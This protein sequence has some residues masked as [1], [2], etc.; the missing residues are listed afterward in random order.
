MY[1]PHTRRWTEGTNVYVSGLALALRSAE[2]V[3]YNEREGDWSSALCSIEVR[4]TPGLALSTN[5]ISMSDGQNVTHTNMDRGMCDRAALFAGDGGVWV[6]REPCRGARLRAAA[7]A[8]SGARAPF[9]VLQR[10]GALHAAQ[11]RREEHQH[12]A[13]YPRERPTTT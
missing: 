8:R 11:E 13:S 5:S 12:D 6:C 2:G 1:V 3:R 7:A 4:T 10:E 9:A